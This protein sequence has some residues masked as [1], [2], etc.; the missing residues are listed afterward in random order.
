MI[1]NE[2][3]IYRGCRHT[4]PGPRRLRIADFLSGELERAVVSTMQRVV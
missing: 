1:V 2:F 4:Q 3:T